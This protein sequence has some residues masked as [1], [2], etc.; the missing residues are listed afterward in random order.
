MLP[1]IDTS[2]VDLTVDDY[3]Y[4]NLLFVADSMSSKHSVSIGRGSVPSVM[5]NENPRN[6]NEY[7]KE[8][9]ALFVGKKVKKANNQE[10]SRSIH[11]YGVV[12]LRDVAHSE[13]R[14][15]KLR[16]TIAAKILY[17]HASA[18]VEKTQMDLRQ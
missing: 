8:D 2:V 17:L 12:V 16:I 7:R 5:Q 1:Y 10:A 6:F 11:S 9:A 18:I 3:S 15:A 4:I 14:N 13:I